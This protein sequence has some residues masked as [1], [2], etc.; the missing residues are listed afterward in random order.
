M[1]GVMAVIVKVKTAEI[2]KVEIVAIGGAAGKVVREAA[3]VV[4]AAAA[5]VVAAMCLPSQLQ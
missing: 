5:P 2:E 4:A 3:A 1:L